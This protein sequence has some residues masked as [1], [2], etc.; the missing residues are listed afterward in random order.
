L[1]PALASPSSTSSSPTPL[2][3]IALSQWLLV[4]R[5]TEFVWIQPIRDLS[6]SACQDLLLA[7]HKLHATDL[8]D[9][10]VSAPL[11]FAMPRT[12]EVVGADLRGQPKTIRTL[13]THDPSDGL[14]VN[15]AESAAHQLVFRAAHYMEQGCLAPHLFSSMLGAA[16]CAL[17][18]CPRMSPHISASRHQEMFQVQPDVSDFPAVPGALVSYLVA[19]GAPE[20]ER[21]RPGPPPRLA[22]E[23]GWCR[24]GVVLP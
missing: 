13:L 3:E 6:L 4:D 7:Y 2:R 11:G 9:I 8:L 1:E 22:S 19:R 5:A 10:D 17:N 12:L 23:A 24:G 15:P 21:R 16:A 20:A 14:L 18:Y